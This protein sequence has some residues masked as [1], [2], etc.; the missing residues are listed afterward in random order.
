MYAINLR[1]LL[2]GDGHDGE[3]GDADQGEIREFRIGLDLGKRHGPLES[4]GGLDIYHDEPIIVT[5]G[6]RIGTFHDL[7]LA[8]DGFLR[9]GVIEE[10]AV[11]L[12]H[13]PQVLQGEVVLHSVPHGSLVAEEVVQ[14]VVVRLL[15]E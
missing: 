8:D 15:F 10:H 5:R 6:V 2:L 13:R 1:P 7:H 11:P 14:G 9:P 4:A 3:P 12:F